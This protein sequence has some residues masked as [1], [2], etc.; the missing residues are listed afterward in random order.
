VVNTVSKTDQVVDPTLGNKTPAAARKALPAGT[1][2]P[3]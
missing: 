3:G 2:Q 1:A